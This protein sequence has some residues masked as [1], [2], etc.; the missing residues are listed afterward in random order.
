GVPEWGEVRFSV[1]LKKDGSVVV[2]YQPRDPQSFRKAVE[3][4]RGLGMRDRCEGDWCMVHFTDREPEGSE[5]GIVYITADGL[6][7]IGWLA[8]H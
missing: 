1:K 6:R 7:Y 2:E 4:L 8:L 5:K 3:L